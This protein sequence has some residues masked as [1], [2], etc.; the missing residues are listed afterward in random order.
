MTNLARQA[1][2]VDGGI[3]LPGIMVSIM[4]LSVSLR[5]FAATA[6]ASLGHVL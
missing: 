1:A 2:A 6:I 5:S 3:A 4:V